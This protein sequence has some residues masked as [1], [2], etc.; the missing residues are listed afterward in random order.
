MKK[1]KLDLD[2][3]RVSS[4]TVRDEKGPTGTVHAN[5]ASADPACGPSQIWDSC[6]SCWPQHCNPQPISWD[7]AC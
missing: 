1:L 3:I 6:Y 5:G 4:F 2:Q 7:F